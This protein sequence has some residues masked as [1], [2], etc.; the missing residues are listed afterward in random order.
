MSISC[1][2]SYAEGVDDYMRL[3]S[4]QGKVVAAAN[5]TARVARLYTR[6][7][8]LDSLI[9]AT[10]Q[11]S[12]VAYLADLVQDGAGLVK[13]IKGNDRLKVA[14]KTYDTSRDSFKVYKFGAKL[15]LFKL[16]PCAGGIGAFF[17]IG[18]FIENINTVR[19]GILEYSDAQKICNRRYATRSQKNIACQKMK[20]S[21]LKTINA[22][23]W[24]I[25]SSFS[26]SAFFLGTAASSEVL[27]VSLYSIALLT[28]VTKYFLKDVLEKSNK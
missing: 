23:I 4:G 6:T 7:S 27:L 19:N 28:S 13:A 12:S 5:L 16:V 26:L 14:K 22:T 2:Y 25:A 20:I 17:S 9:H 8:R 3:S 18:F 11:F 21:M 1:N 24:I 15:D 10:G